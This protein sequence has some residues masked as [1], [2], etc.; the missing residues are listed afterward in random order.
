MKFSSQFQL[1][2]IISQEIDFLVSSVSTPQPENPNQLA[3]E[4][5]PQTATDSQTA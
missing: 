3:R 1:T 4:R 2:S 5:Q